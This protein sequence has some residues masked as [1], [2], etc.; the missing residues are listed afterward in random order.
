MTG[1]RFTTRADAWT[2]RIILIFSSTLLFLLA[3][4]A[5]LGVL[6]SHGVDV[7]IPDRFADAT[8]A[9]YVGCWLAPVLYTVLVDVLVWLGIR[10]L[11]EDNSPWRVW[12][13]AATTPIAVIA[14]FVVMTNW[15]ASISAAYDASQR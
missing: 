7:R 15:S 13:L 4:Y 3:F 2:A 5:G 10:R 9:V 12:W 6:L 11:R 14:A 8:V 1:R